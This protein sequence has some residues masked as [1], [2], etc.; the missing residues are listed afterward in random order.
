MSLFIQ[1]CKRTDEYDVS[2]IQ[3]IIFSSCGQQVNINH[4]LVVT[5]TLEQRRIRQLAH[6]HFYV[7][8]C[9]FLIFHIDIQTNS[10]A[11]VG[12]RYGLFF[13]QIFYIVNFNFENLLQ[14]LFADALTAHDQLEH[15]IV[16]YGQFFPWFDFIRHNTRPFFIFIIQQTKF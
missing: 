10:L 15:V 3:L 9:V 12:S 1:N 2:I 8:D 6:L 5:G 16:L 7:I 11:L 13:L 4:R 14:H